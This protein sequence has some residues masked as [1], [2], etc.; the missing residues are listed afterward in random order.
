MFNIYLFILLFISSIQRRLIPQ[1]C[2]IHISSNNHLNMYYYYADFSQ[3]YY[4]VLTYTTPLPLIKHRPNHQVNSLR[5]K[6]HC[7]IHCSRPLFTILETL[8]IES[9]IEPSAK[10]KLYEPN[11]CIFYTLMCLQS[12]DTR[13]DCGACHLVPSVLQQSIKKRDWHTKIPG[14]KTTR[15]NQLLFSA[16][17]GSRCYSQV[18]FH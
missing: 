13:Y 1:H 16:S 8:G 3:I 15:N 12:S 7:H 9:N 4:F 18:L 11:K 5:I 14:N 10:F 2:F 17:E 6:Y